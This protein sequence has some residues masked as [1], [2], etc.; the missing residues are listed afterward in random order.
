MK[1]ILKTSILAIILAVIANC[2]VLAQKWEKQH[3]NILYAVDKNGNATNLKVGI[4]TDNPLFPLEVK[5]KIFTDTLQVLKSIEIGNSIYLGSIWQPGTNELFTDYSSMPPDLFIQSNALYQ[6]N[7]TI[8]NAN[9]NIGRALIGINVPTAANAKLE[10]NGNINMTNPTNGYNINGEYVLRHKGNTQNIFA[11]V[12]AGLNNTFGT[13]NT[14]MGN[15]AGHD[16]N[17]ATD[18]TFIGFNAGYHTYLLGG[19]GG[20]NTF[21]GSLA[22]YT[23]TSGSANTA[24]GSQALYWNTTGYYNIANGSRA[25]FNNTTGVGNIANGVSALEKNTEGD[26]NIA[27]GLGALYNNIIGDQNT[28]YGEE[29]LSSNT[30]YYNTAIGT[31]A[32]YSNTT[33]NYNTYLGYS[34]R[35]SA[36]LNNATSIGAHA[37][38]ADDNSMLLWT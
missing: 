10:V 14:Y 13:R 33:G 2:A 21:V 23:N 31:G 4:N 30:G 25:L 3:P 18:E 5:G 28:A 34:T 20:F 1:T 16:N 27:T 15:D 19:G 26:G 38:V 22:G 9:G 17:N 32:G 8:M 6:T 7:N 12:G 37:W 11:G 24:T 29:A 36:S 35:G